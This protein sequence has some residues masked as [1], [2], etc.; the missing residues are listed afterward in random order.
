M[1]GGRDSNP[2][3]ADHAGA[4]VDA[5]DPHGPDFGSRLV[6][7]V[8]YCR[9]NSSFYRER[10][11]ELG[12]TPEE[13]DSLEALASLPV[14]LDKASEAASQEQSRV[15][16]GHPF[17]MH[18]CA[19]VEDVVGVA[20]TSGTTGDPTYYAFTAKDIALTDSQWA[21]AFELGGV[22]PGD[23]VLH[24]FGLS[25][26]LAGVPVVRALERMGARPI[27]VGAE[28]GSDRLTK[29]GLHMRPR[30]ICCTPS[31]GEYLID[32]GVAE[33]FGV[34][35]IFCAGEPGAGLPEVRERLSEGFGGATVTDILG[36]VHG[37]INVSCEAHAGMHMLGEAHSVQQLMDADTGA[38]VPLRDGAVGVRVKT[39]LD[40][41]AQPQL[42]ASVGDVYEVFT[43]RC[44]CGRSEPRARV[45]GRVDD[46]L[47][48]KGVKV[49]PATIQNLVF[50]FRPRLTGHFRI[51]LPERGP[52]VAP[53][54]K[55]RVEVEE[56]ADGA[57]AELASAMHSRLA[58]TPEIEAVAAGSLERE[59]HKTRL[60]ELVSD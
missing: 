37:V 34:E 29:V 4:P 30:A 9:D 15:E 23:P 48:V 56:G 41:Q 35:H 33:E 26:F 38:N 20:S 40:W 43:S 39:T 47:I 32:K 19:P 16:L 3:V 24:A 17:G 12:V 59:S 6:E 58:V 49:Y 13:I 57:L 27:P 44:K 14:L 7:S 8:R 54:L 10:L 36:G 45:I 50:E 42:R 5:A 18:L 60:I 53:P 25:M 46:L 11:D 2:A 22:R 52:K 1:D 51:M 55:M 21:A 28:A 31:Y